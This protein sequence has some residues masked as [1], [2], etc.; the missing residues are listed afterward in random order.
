MSFGAS[1]TM[2]TFPYGF[3]NGVSIRN[4]PFAQTQGGQ[5]FWVYNGSA[6][7]PTGRPGSDNNRGTFDAPFASIAGALTACV[8]NRGDILMVKPG[9]AESITAATLLDINVAGVQIVGLGTGALRP[10]LTLSGA[11]AATLTISGAGASLRNFIIDLT[12]IDAIAAG[13]TISASGVGLFDNFVRVAS[14][15]AQAT[16]GASVLTGLSGVE[17]A[18]NSFFGTANAGTTAALQIVGGDN[19][20]V[21]ENQF[22]GNYTA[23]TGAISNITTAVS[24]LRILRNLIANNTASSTKV[25]TC[26]SGTTGQIADNR[27]QILSGSA[28]I[29]AAAMS[30]VGANYYAATIATAGTLI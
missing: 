25:I 24:N 4:M 16:L 1:P 17:I 5:I 18:G 19:H 28:P 21:A 23:G 8:A 2:S 26:L 9:H 11:T 30:W 3:G 14:A 7:P 13:I 6:L 12:G 20:L 15:S 22:F 27:M 29:T 10:T